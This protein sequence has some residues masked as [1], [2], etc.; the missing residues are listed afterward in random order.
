MNQNKIFIVEDNFLYSYV[1]EETLK[2]HG[3][4]KI[5]TFASAEECIE[6]LDNNPQ[7]IILD[8]NLENGMNGLDAFKI[9]HQKKPKI[10][11][12]VL[13]AQKD[14]QI[15][16]DLLKKGVFDYIEKKDNEKAMSRLLN[17]IL[18]AFDIKN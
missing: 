8:Y 14:V 12:I 3:N 15:A 7:I 4:F 1:L 9:I 6:M 11:V 16:A 17:S 18:K 13:S 5:T 10:K 2:E